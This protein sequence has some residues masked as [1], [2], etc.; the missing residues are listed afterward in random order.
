MTAPVLNLNSY[1]HLIKLRW[2]DRMRI[3]PPFSGCKKFARSNAKP[4]QPEHIPFLGVYFIEESLSSDGEDN[5]AVPGFDAELNLGFSYVIRNND[6]DA[7]EDMLDA[8]YWSFMKLLHDPAWAEFPDRSVRVEGIRG[9]KISR[10]YG[11]LTEQGQR[12]MFAETP[13]AELRMEMTYFHRF[14]FDPLTP[15]PFEIYHSTIAIVPPGDPE[16]VKPI[17]V[18]LNLPQ[19]QEPTP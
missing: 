14:Y 1:G 3:I 19:D 16:A 11:N 2:L 4:T 17:I 9:G 6:P 15:D 13:Y 12:G 8:A 7:A 18:L 10:H 5:Q